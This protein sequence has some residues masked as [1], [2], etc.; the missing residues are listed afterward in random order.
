MKVFPLGKGKVVY[1]EDAESC[2][3]CVN[4]FQDH[5]VTAKEKFV[6]A[7]ENCK[8]IEE[9]LTQAPIYGRSVLMRR[10]SGESISLLRRRFM[11]IALP[12]SKQILTI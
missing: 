1:N 7:M 3:L 8:S 12:G 10:L 9:V 6:K 2:L 11:N 5:A 4:Y